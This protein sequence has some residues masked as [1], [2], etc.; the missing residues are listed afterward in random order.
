MFLCI[1]WPFRC[2]FFVCLFD[3]VRIFK[4]TE[5]IC[6]LL[7]FDIVLPMLLLRLRSCCCCFCCIICNLK[8]NIFIENKSETSSEPSNKKCLQKLCTSILGLFSAKRSREMRGQKILL[9][10]CFI[11][12]F[13]VAFFSISGS[14]DTDDAGVSAASVWPRVP[15]VAVGRSVGSS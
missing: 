7:Y 8:Q 3:F 9:F 15:V 2:F 5:L 11:S 6:Y 4:T 10:C 13:F 14:A 1:F 12:S